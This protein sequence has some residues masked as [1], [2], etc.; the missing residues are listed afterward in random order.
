MLKSFSLYR[1]T[2]LIFVLTAANFAASAV[3][4]NKAPVKRSPAA[5]AA[6][7]ENRKISLE[8]EI[9]ALTAKLEQLQQDSLA[10][11]LDL[12]GNAS[13]Q[14]DKIAA[15]DA[16]IKTSAA[17][18]ADL[19]TQLNKVR[20]D[21]AAQWSEYREQA[22]AARKQSV[23]NATALLIASNELATLNRQ[24]GNL[25]GK[26]GAG[27]ERIVNLLQAQ[28]AH[29]DSLIHS[30]Q[31]EILALKSKRD[32]VGQDSLAEESRASEGRKRLAPELRRLDSLLTPLIAE[33]QNVAEKQLK[34]KQDIAEKKTRQQQRLVSLTNQKT[35]LA[36]S[37]QRLSK[38]LA[39]VG[40]RR[41]ADN[42]AA[43]AARQKYDQ[44]RAPLVAALSS[45]ESAFKNAGADR[46]ALVAFQ[47][48]M[49]FSATIAKAK[50]ALDAIIQDAAKGKRGAKKHSEDKENEINDLYRQLDEFSHAPGVAAKHAQFKAYSVEQTKIMVDSLVSASNQQLVG[51]AQKVD[52]ARKA[53][54]DF[55]A[56]R[57][58]PGAT[59]PAQGGQLDSLYSSKERSITQI[60]AQ[61]DSLDR[62]ITGLQNTSS[63][64]DVASFSDLGHGDSALRVIDKKKADLTAER[65][66]AKSDSLAIEAA[67]ARALLRTRNDRLKNTGA[68]AAAQ[69][70]LAG[71][72]ER[73][74]RTQQSIVEA[75]EKN[76]LAASLAEQEGRRLDS[77]IG[78]K[79]QEVNAL[80]LQKEQL[81]KENRAIT[82]RFDQPLKRIA[83]TQA[84]VDSLVRQKQSEQT[85]L[86]RQ[87]AA[88]LRSKSSGESGLTVKLRTITQELASVSR[89]IAADRTTLESIQTQEAQ[90]AQRAAQVNQN[91]SQLD[92]QIAALQA[93]RDQASHKTNTAAETAPAPAPAA[94]L[95]SEAAQQPAVP[96][97]GPA[98]QAQNYLVSIYDL[99]SKNKL[100]EAMN[101]FV[102]HRAQLKKYLDRDV[103]NAIQMTIDQVGAEQKK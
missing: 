64:F 41:D 30:R 51:P 38:E 62:L 21:S 23:G 85:A 25:A 4:T 73:A 74:Q 99:V 87:K 46:D 57:P 71:L 67:A 50:E 47:K 29:L 55:D 102:I 93:Q 26:G 60:T 54:A 89:R 3:R 36:A 81:S 5:S 75:Q 56:A 96:A 42:H 22:A 32:Q 79:Q 6:S 91:V 1:L 98:E 17:D 61:K 15:L 52:I 2:V 37:I 35:E 78:L 97:S 103:Y 68:L 59:S 48:E 90:A 40:A 80:S 13:T 14:S 76:R 9:S 49:Q 88:A 28:A 77:L 84:H 82:E 69:Q 92:S 58:A 27:G 34:G 45:A 70:D 95:Q 86:M 65:S 12:S 19:K 72:S 66:R 39:I 53:L 83:Q 18:L 11:A 16:D 33:R 20:Q 8:N 7:L 24:R 63:E 10:T 44:A 100:H 43:S 31:A 94:P 101:L